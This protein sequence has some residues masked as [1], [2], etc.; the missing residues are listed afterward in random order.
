M[1][2]IGLGAIAATA[3]AGFA[4]TPDK[5]T[6]IDELLAYNKPDNRELLIKTYGD[7]GITGFLKLTGAIKNGGQADLIQYW[8]EQRRHRKVLPGT[9]TGGSGVETLGTPIVNTSADFLEL[10]TVVMNADDGLV[11]IVTGLDGS[12]STQ[13]LTRLDGVLTSANFTATTELIILGNMYDQGSDQPSTFMKTEPTKRLN[14]YMIIKDRYEVNGSQATNIGWVNV[15][16]DYRWYVHGEQET[17]RRFEDRREMMMLF[18]ERTAAAGAAVPSYGGGSEGYFSAVND[19]G[20]IVSNASANPLDSFAEFDSIILELDKQ[21]APSEYAMYVNRNQSLAIDDM[22][23]A[24]IATNVTAGLAGQFGAFNND[25]DMA[26]QLGFKSFTRGGY[27]FHKH[28]WKLMNDP[29]LLGASTS[30]VGA[31]VPMTQVTDPVSGAKAPALEMNYKESNG[32]SR[33][34][35]HWVRGGGVLGHNE[36][37]EDILEMNYRSEIALVTRAA[38]QHVIIKG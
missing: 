25:T 33:E 10:N 28:D 23:A 30:Y 29:Q 2:T 36:L 21:G 16:G 22:L 18:A 31:M 11:Y 19:R 34:L 38:N 5:Y 26:V 15:G 9:S 1:A 13:V 20:I 37:T 32:Y 17:R 8:E 27:T 4:T 14:S 7:Q 6:T 35:E 3:A 12:G 24:G